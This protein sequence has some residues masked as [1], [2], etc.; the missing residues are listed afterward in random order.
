MPDNNEMQADGRREEAPTKGSS[1]RRRVR[2]ASSLTMLLLAVGCSADSPHVLYHNRLDSLD[3]I[4]ST[5]GL[6]LDTATSRGVAVRIHSPGPT[7]IRLARVRTDDAD[8]VVLTFRGHLRA[9][10]LMGHAYLEMRCVVP[11]R[12][13][14]FS[15]VLQG[16]VTGTTDWVNQVTRLSLGRH[17]GSQTVDLN[18][19]VEGA[20]VVWIDNVLLA[21]AAR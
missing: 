9:E 17:P 2:S 19:H 5:T 3:G 18:V 4:I 1:G 10:G 15:T 13:E 16:P 11:G 20:G 8:A 12:G 7:T 6:T 21:Q 14:L